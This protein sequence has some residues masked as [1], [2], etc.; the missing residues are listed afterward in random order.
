[1]AETTPL[2]GFTPIQER[3]WHDINDLSEFRDKDAPGWTRQVFSDPFRRSRQWLAATMTAAGL[4][5]EVDAACNVVGVLPGTDPSLPALVTGSHTDTVRGGGRFDGI[6]GVLGAIE[7]VRLLGE[8]GVRLRHSLKVVD[9]A[10][11]EAND[12]GISCVGSRALSG[13]LSAEHLELRDPTGRT[14]ADALRDAGGDPA[15]ALQLAWTPAEV[16][17]FVELH[18]EQGPVLEA[19]GTAVGVVTGI[20]GIHRMTAVFNGRGD[21]AGTTPMHMRR[22]AACAAAEAILAVEA[23]V[24][25]DQVSTTGRVTVEPG[26]SNV[27]PSRAELLSEFRSPDAQ[28]LRANRALVNE[29]L[30]AIAAR[31][32]MEVAIEWLMGEEPV[33]CAPEL[34]EAI[35][36][37][38]EDLGLSHRR[39][40]SGAGH[41]AVMM[42]ELA[43]VGM[44]FVPSRDG[45]SHVEEEWTDVED[46]ATGVQVLAETLVRLDSTL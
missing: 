6:V 30:Q 37:V 33:V 5:A 11:E 24:S 19:T 25:G 1:M 15:T 38:V 12:F 22:D 13:N 21:H 46:I 18:V 27:V 17:R 20:A 28:W 9:F 32:G 43:P 34:V 45:R 42:A 41:D 26:A 35:E 44:I 4:D 40:P 14:L 39:M 3:L 7:A 29:K 23:S 2:A 36:Q 10:G 8:A 31:R 16:A